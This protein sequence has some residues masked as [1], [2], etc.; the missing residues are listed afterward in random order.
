MKRFV[1]VLIAAVLILGVLCQSIYADTAQIEF[2]KTNVKCGEFVIVTLKYTAPYEMYGIVFSLTYDES[3]LQHKSG[4][5][6]IGSTVRIV[7]ALSG[8]K[9]YTDTVAFRAVSSGECLLSFTAEGSGCGS[10]H[11]SA[12]GVLDVRC[13]GD[14][15]GDGQLN[16]KDLTR[17]FQYL[18]DW[19]VE[20]NESM[21]DING[22]G[23][24]NN[25]DLTRLFQF[26]S[27]WYVEI[28]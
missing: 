25:K 6:S 17:L 4:G 11:S 22:D 23:K 28:F 12:L 27:D 5:T 18:S 14:V 24:I 8:E 9:E 15:N 19:D 21:L 3:V 20:V 1:S 2:S 16:N 26:L 13:V 7:E 10:G